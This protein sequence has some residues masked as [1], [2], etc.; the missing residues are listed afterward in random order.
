MRK[1]LFLNVTQQLIFEW[2]EIGLFID[3]FCRKVKKKIQNITDLGYKF[4][5]GHEL[6]GDIEFH[7]GIHNL[8][9]T[10]FFCNAESTVK[11]KHASGN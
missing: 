3:S 11:K 8:Q 5:D 2:E 7:E 10:I 6:Q 4:E 1:V 9:F